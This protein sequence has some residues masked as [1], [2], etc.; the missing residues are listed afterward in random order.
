MNATENPV[1]EL[2]TKISSLKNCRYVVCTYA[3]ISKIPTFLMVRFLHLGIHVTD[4]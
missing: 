1:F 2:I 3:L 4:C